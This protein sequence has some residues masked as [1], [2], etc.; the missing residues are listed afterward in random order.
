MKWKCS[1]CGY[2]HDGDSAPDVCPKCGSPKEK[3]EKI[4]PDVEQLIDRSRKTN[5][6][7]MDLT[8]ILTKII[9]ISEEGIADNLDPNC[10]SIFQKAKKA[11]HE[12]RQMS[13]AEIVAHISKQKWG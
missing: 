9:A 2:I 10:L 8:H 7:H 13:K 5:Q 6:L 12:L 11:A 4:A 3:F 1:V